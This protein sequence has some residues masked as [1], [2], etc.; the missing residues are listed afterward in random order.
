MP[1]NKL[2]HASRGNKYQR[3]SLFISCSASR[4]D[5]LLLVSLVKT[6]ILVLHWFACVGVKQIFCRLDWHHHIQEIVLP[7]FH[8]HV[9]I[10]ICVF[11]CLFILFPPPLCFSFSFKSKPQSVW[12][13]IFPFEKAWS[14]NSYFAV[15]RVMFMSEDHL[16]VANLEKYPSCWI[17]WCKE[18]DDVFK[19]VFFFFK[20]CFSEG[21]CC[22]ENGKIYFH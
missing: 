13:Q 14:L 21:K 17:F 1:P 22:S 5:C 18:R 2:K 6:Y 4:W 20:Y 7:D 10:Y 11:I 19:T 15:Y 3:R 12:T 9:H 8:W 16:R